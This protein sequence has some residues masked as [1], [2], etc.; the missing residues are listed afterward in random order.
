MAV[1][2]SFW[3]WLILMRTLCTDIFKMDSL[4]T[5]IDLMSQNCYM[6]SFDW[7][8]A[9][10]SVPVAKS[11]QKYLRFEWRGKLYQ[12]TCYPNGLGSAPRNFTKLAKVIFCEL[13]KR[14]HICTNYIDDCLVLAPNVEK[15]KQ[16]VRE[17]VH[18]SEMAGFITHPEKSMLEPSTEDSLPGVCA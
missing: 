13:R 2:D 1:L 15:C 5:A 16:S 10:Y 11:F 9:Y 17:T 8:D 6:A 12:Y 18:M 14:G 7:K 4:N 3:I